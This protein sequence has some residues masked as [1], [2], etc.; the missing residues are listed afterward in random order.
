M[1]NNQNQ[2]LYFEV[3]LPLFVIKN[4]KDFFSQEQWKDFQDV[5]RLIP[6]RFSRLLNVI[7]LHY[8]AMMMNRLFLEILS[9]LYTK[10]LGLFNVNE[11]LNEIFLVLVRGVRNF[12]GGWSH[13]GLF[14]QKIMKLISISLEFL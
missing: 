5:K 2:V 12:F 1:W 3:H 4:G 14:E 7:L 9:T 11:N 10:N 8:H 6:T 13:S